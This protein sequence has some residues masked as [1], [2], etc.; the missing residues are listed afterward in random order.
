M[1]DQMPESKNGVRPVE[2][3][4]AN[5]WKSLEELADTPAFRERLER[6]FPAGASEMNDAVDRRRFLALMGAS[7]G[8]AG[9]TA[10]TKQPKVTFAAFSNP[11]E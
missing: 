5:Y 1:K 4:G 6:E 7:L 2:Q 11:P 9:V 8:L 3:G 10:C